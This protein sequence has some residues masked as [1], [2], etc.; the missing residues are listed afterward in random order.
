MLTFSVRKCLVLKQ[1]L[2]TLKRY[3]VGSIIK[4]FKILTAV[5]GHAIPQAI[6]RLL[7]RQYIDR[8]L[9]GNLWIGNL[10]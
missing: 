3:S 8:L 4:M 2:N 7:V 10:P 6:A 5:F 1:N 9:T